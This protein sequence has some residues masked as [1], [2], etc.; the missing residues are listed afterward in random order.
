MLG[1][2]YGEWWKERPG[3][4]RTRN[5]LILLPFLAVAGWVLHLAISGARPGD[6]LF[7]AIARGDS[8]HASAEIAKGTSPNARRPD[9]TTP[10]HWALEYGHRD[11]ALMLM[12][13]GSDVGAVDGY[14]VT[15]LHRATKL[16]DGEI[17]RLLLERGAD[18]GARS[19]FYGTPLHW[20]AVGRAHRCP[21]SAARCR[22]AGGS[23]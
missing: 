3:T 20:A 18:A 11:L 2:S 9:G 10:L 8:H 21:A 12:Q 7:E 19:P 5:A 4:R 1:P 16:G 13:E 15:A 14:G 23:R 6:A 17:V 22:R